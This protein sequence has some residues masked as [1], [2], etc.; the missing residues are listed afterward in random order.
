[1]RSGPAKT[2]LLG[3]STNTNVG[4]GLH[5]SAGSS[6]NRSTR[7]NVEP[8]AHPFGVIGG[9]IPPSN[10]WTNAPVMD[11]YR[12]SGESYYPPLPGVQASIWTREPPAETLALGNR[13]ED[14]DPRWEIHR[15]VPGL[16]KIAPPQ[17]R[18]KHGWASPPSWDKDTSD[19]QAIPP[20]NY[21][22]PA[23]IL[24][25]ESSL[26]RRLPS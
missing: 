6:Q 9:P 5:R 22:L 16:V 18:F 25:G 4:S 1:M 14:Q 20:E 13:F 19:P 23:N 26:A 10:P 17:D 21:I 12:P 11:E 8:A 2:G 15:F 3:P 24:A 7:Q